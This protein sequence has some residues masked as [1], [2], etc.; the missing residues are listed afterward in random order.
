MKTIVIASRT[1]SALAGIPLKDLESELVAQGADVVKLDINDL[2]GKISGDLIVLYN[3]SYRVHKNKF[4]RVDVPIFNTPR[5][6][7]KHRQYKILQDAGVPIPKYDVIDKNSNLEKVINELGMPMITKPLTGTG[8]RGVVL[9]T[10]ERDLRRSLSQRKVIAQKYVKEASRGDVRVLVID[11]KAIGALWRTPRSGRVASNFHAGGKPSAYD[12]SDQ[13]KEVAVAAAKA[14]GLT[15][16]G[17][18]LVPTSRGPLVLEANSVPDLMHFKEV[19]GINAIPAYAA[20][21]IKSA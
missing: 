3:S 6:Y 4:R 1:K 7:G 5:E 13:E 18:D 11:G 16:S 14:M 10:S 20:A 8:G 19:A 21:I 9:Q 15:I 2:P 12:A 17:V